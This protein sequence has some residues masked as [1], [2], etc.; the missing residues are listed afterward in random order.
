MNVVIIDYGAGNVFSVMTA[1]QRLGVRPV[2]S[3]EEMVIRRADRVIFPGVGQASAA[4][5]QLK[6]T[7]LH[8]LIPQLKMPVLGICLGMQLM[9][10]QTEEEQT[11][12]LGIFPLEVKRFSSSVKVPHMGWNRIQNLKTSLFRGVESGDWVYFV[13][14]YYLPFC[15]DTVAVC[16]YQQQFSAAVCRENFYGCQFHPE[17]SAA[18]G[19]KILKNFLEIA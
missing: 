7:S 2:L 17:K 11:T 9:C 4:M 8:I 16:D 1:L 3:H 13:H 5:Q 6:N 10:R 12:G 19:E 18:V 14:S 15:D